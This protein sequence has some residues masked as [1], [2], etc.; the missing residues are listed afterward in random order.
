M[1]IKITK[2]NLVTALKTVKSTVTGRGG[3][4]I[5]MN[6]HLEAKK[7]GKLVLTTT[8]IDAT[9][10]TSAECD[11]AEPG[12]TTLPHAILL[13]IASKLQD[14]EVTIEVDSREKAVIRGGNSVFKL[15][16]IAA[17]EFPK[18]P[19]EDDAK[20]FTV[21]GKALAGQLRLVSYAS[22]TDDTRRT[23]KSVL[24]SF[25]DQKLRLVAT[26]GRRL[27]LCNEPQQYKEGQDE[28]LVIPSIVIG[29]LIRFLSDSDGDVTISVAKT[30]IKIVIGDITMYSK[31]IDD[32]FPNYMQVIPSEDGTQNIQVDTEQLR[33][34]IDRVSVFSDLKETHSVKFSFKAGRLVISANCET[35]GASDEIPIK[36]SGEDID[37]ILNP[38]YVLD[39]LKA[40]TEDEITIRL[41]DGHTP[42]VITTSMDFIYVLMPLR[43]Q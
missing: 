35:G 22:S 11:V 32:H 24:F 12:V 14:G 18:L 29:D 27:A 20:V 41:K 39:P 15:A 38:V 2:S 8:N 23:L 31:M 19:A 5:L 7:D 21:V 26:D 1:K 25:K 9:L 34:A 13:T 43:I 17:S 42:A 37:I 36:Y 16:G 3:L 33:E 28:D 30:Q 6:V 10:R 40:I 4:P